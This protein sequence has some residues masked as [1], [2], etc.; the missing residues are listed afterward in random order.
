MAHDSS[1]KEVYNKIISSY[2]K[3]IKSEFLDHPYY[4]RFLSYLRVGQKVLD[5]G[6][7]TA[8]I[9]NE[10]MKLHGLKIVAIDN[11]KEMV[12]LGKKKYP[13]LNYRE[14]DMRNL[15]FPSSIFHAIIANYSLI[16]ILEYDVESTIKEFARVLKSHGYLYLALQSPI[17]PK[18]KDGYYPVRYKKGTSLFINLFRQEEIVLYLKKAGFKILRID[19]RKPDKKTEF[20]FNKLFMIAQKK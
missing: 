10:M 20:P 3:N 15:K 17:T 5:A 4:E 16:H 2:C 7:G 9:A 14:M 12:K 19:M 8:S 13:S 1:T 6:A 11:S 18:Q